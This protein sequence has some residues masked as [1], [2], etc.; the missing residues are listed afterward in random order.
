MAANS[1]FTKVKQC[2]IGKHLT[3]VTWKCED[4]EKLV[5]TI[6][7]RK[8]TAQVYVIVLRSFGFHITCNK[9]KERGKTRHCELWI[10]GSYL[11]NYSSTSSGL[12][13]RHFVFFVGDDFP[14]T[15]LAWWAQPVKNVSLEVLEMIKESRL[16]KSIHAVT[17]GS[18]NV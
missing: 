1:D 15:K 10:L 6:C 2:L 9:Y 17:A 7:T 5:H 4:P 12:S 8:T 13:V 18:E 3:K 16:L 14:Q 11:N